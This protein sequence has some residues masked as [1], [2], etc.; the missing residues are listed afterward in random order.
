MNWWSSAQIDF[1][2]KMPELDFQVS[3]L[4]LLSYHSVSR[5]VWVQLSYT[6]TLLVPELQFQQ[7]EMLGPSD[8]FM[9]QPYTKPLRNPV[10][11][12]LDRISIDTIIHDHA[13][14][15]MDVFAESHKVRRMLRQFNC[16]WP[17]LDIIPFQQMLDVIRIMRQ[18]TTKIQWLATLK[19][20]S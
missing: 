13:K 16:N 14:C 8:P 6:S 17:E 10:S 15:S 2:T 20:G 12:Y 19:A 7:N 18:A 4:V 3:E 11:V 1:P 9:S 5:H